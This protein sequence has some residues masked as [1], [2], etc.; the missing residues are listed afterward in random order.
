MIPTKEDLIRITER[1]AERKGWRKQDLLKGTAREALYWVTGPEDCPTIE[2]AVSAYNP[3]EDLNQAE[4]ELRIYYDRPFLMYRRVW[5]VYSD[6]WKFEEYEPV[7]E[8]E[9]LATAICIALVGWDEELQA[10]RK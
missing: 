2:R 7:G 4:E 5:R 3:T 1:L 9:N 6:Y 10:M 8:H